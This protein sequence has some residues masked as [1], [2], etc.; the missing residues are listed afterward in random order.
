MGLQR[1]VPYSQ[2]LWQRGFVDIIY[3]MD[4]KTRRL[5]LVIQ[6]DL[7]QAPGYLNKAP[8]TWWELREQLKVQDQHVGMVG[9][10]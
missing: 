9:P 5:P 1:M 2:N 6:V 3:I 10:F 7:I 8:Q 4:I